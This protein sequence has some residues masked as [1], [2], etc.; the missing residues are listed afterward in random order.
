M[1]L[2]RT[3][4]CRILLSTVVVIALSA[5][6]GA[7]ETDTHYYLTFALA[8]HSCFDWDEA[9]LIASGN[10]M[11]DE[12]K[13]TVAE[14]GLFR[15][16]NKR[17]W[18]AFGHSEERL[19]Q[20]WFRAVREK[21]PQIRLVKLGQFFHF[22]QDWE[23][24]AG[25]P[26]GLGHALATITGKDPDSLAKARDRSARMGQSTADHLA[27]MC[28]VLGRLP[29]GI[30]DPVIGFL[31]MTEGA[32]DHVLLAELM[33]ESDPRW[34]LPWGDLSEEGKKILAQNR[35]RIEQFIDRAVRPRPGKKVPD[36]FRP[37][38]EAHGIPRALRLRFDGAGDLTESLDKAIAM[39]REL[40]S[41]DVDPADVVVAVEKAVRVKDGWSVRVRIENRGDVRPRG[42]ELTLLRLM[43]YDALTEERLGEVW[44]KAPP[45]KPQQPVTIETLIPMSRAAKEEMIAI[46]LHVGDLSTRNDTVWFM[47]KK[48]IAELQEDLEA[49]GR[50]ADGRLVQPPVETVEFADEPKLWLRDKKWLIVMVTTRTNLRDPTAQLGL[51]MIRL[52]HENEKLSPDVLRWPPVWTMSVLA[53]GQRPAA[54]T[55]PFLRVSEICE[56]AELVTSSPVLDVTVVAYEPIRKRK[57]GSPALRR[58]RKK[59]G[60][61]RPPPSSPVREVQTSVELDDA[62]TEELRRICTRAGPSGAQDRAKPKE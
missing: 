26:M 49:L 39:T 48:D 50:P 8:L 47:T 60:A 62:L 28:A 19:N 34:R 24:H 7:F 20:L 58:R 61:R 10:A 1:R 40:E 22:L 17:M 59:P 51:P 16:H 53:E 18:H 4:T 30:Q 15:T 21:H 25:Y 9:H 45:L 6:S 38:D 35:L 52:R 31:K 3:R 44:S 33:L 54:K 57:R 42:E 37:G 13:T 29:E 55:F 11:V 14:L 46:T 12:N 32:R 2:A 41:K 43:V 27:K 23:A 36:D 5:E 56:K